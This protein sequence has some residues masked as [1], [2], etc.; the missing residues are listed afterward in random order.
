VSSSRGAIGQSHPSKNNDSMFLHL[1]YWQSSVLWEG[2]AERAV[3]SRIA[4]LDHP[5][6]DL[7][8][9]GQQRYF[10]HTPVGNS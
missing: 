8:R 9:A 2:D 4:V 3:G 6:V 10:E 5:N 1:D 7:L